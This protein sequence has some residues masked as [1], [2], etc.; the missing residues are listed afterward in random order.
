VVDIDEESITRL[1]QW[2]WPHDRLAELTEK[3]G[4]LGDSAIVFDA[5]FPE[6]DR[7]SP[8]ILVERWRADPAMAVLLPAL[9]NLPDND[10]VFARALES[11]STVLGLGLVA[12]DGGINVKPKASFATVGLNPTGG[13][14]R[15]SGMIGNL[16]VPQSAA[17]GTAA[18]SVTANRDVVVRSLP[19]VALVGD[20]LVPSP[21]LEA[22]R[23]ASGASTIIIRRDDQ[24]GARLKNRFM[25][26]EAALD[27][28]A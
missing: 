28:A 12:R 20:M 11:S 3:L 13:L 16:P 5:V 1:G 23:V 17:S 10:M 22:I 21:P 4:R 25:A 7:T 9:A 24:V 8:A 26:G 19:L 6:P 2:P 27:F 18:F 15:Y 14:L